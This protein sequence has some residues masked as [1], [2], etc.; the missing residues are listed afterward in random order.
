MDR[1]TLCKQIDTVITK[2]AFSGKIKRVTG[3]TPSDMIAE[4]VIKNAKRL[5]LNA[6]LSTTIVSD[7]MNFAT[8][9]FFCRYFKRYTGMTPQQWRQ[10]VSGH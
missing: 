7:R 1:A 3:I 4:M 6:S 8:P 5:L 2:F 10:S 9:S